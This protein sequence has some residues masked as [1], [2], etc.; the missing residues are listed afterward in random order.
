MSDSLCPLP[1]TG[2]KVAFGID[3]DN[4]FWNWAGHTAGNSDL[5]EGWLVD[6]TDCSGARCVAVFRIEGQPPSPADGLRVA[7][8][9]VRIGAMPKCYLL[10]EEQPR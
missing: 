3:D 9:L 7:Q 2:C 5:P 10:T 8:L 6:E 1:W 4:A